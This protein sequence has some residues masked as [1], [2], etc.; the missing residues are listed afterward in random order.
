MAGTKNVAKQALLSSNYWV[1]NKI[2]VRK[3]GIEAAF[4]LSVFAEAEN[5][6]ADPKGWFYQTIEKTEEI[7]TLTRW[8]QEQAIKKLIAENLL[9]QVTKGMPRKRYYRIN[10]EV[11]TNLF[12]SDLQTGLRV[13][14]KQECE[15]LTTSKESIDKENNYRE[16]KDIDA[17]VGNIVTKEL[18]NRLQI[19]QEKK[20]NGQMSRQISDKNPPEIEKHTPVYSEIIGYLNDKTESSYKHT[21]KK[22]TDLIKARMNE[23][24]TVEDFKKV[25]DIKTAEWL[26]NPDMNKFL[27]PE[28]L[29]GNKFESYLNQKVGGRD[30]RANKDNK[31]AEGEEIAKRAG[32]LSF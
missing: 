32:I 18:P 10:Y 19:E 15:S 13:A 1:I 23:G 28:T 22:T 4:L 14:Y 24:F 12:A 31:Y 17:G 29:F 30:E 6:M 11:L 16:N 8:K 21:T 9:E 7:T 25:I 27:R 3:F 2:I 20:K 5:M 26:K